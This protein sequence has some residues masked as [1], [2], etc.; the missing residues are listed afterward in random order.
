MTLIHCSSSG[1]NAFSSDTMFDL[2]IRLESIESLEYIGFEN[3]AAV[4][5]YERWANRPDTLYEYVKGHLDEQ[6]SARFDGL[7][8]LETMRKLDVKNDIAEAI[9]D[10][11]YNIIHE[12]QSLFYW[13]ED[14]M[15]ISWFTLQT[16]LER[17]KAFGV[18]AVERNN[19]RN[20]KLT[21]SSS[22]DTKEALNTL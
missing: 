15:D 9:L 8:A 2:P 13:I 1:I 16:I 3:F 4:E 22:D 7:S 11:V 12:T 6:N 21:S 18:E 5:I 17:L 14:T 10:P 20:A 19:S